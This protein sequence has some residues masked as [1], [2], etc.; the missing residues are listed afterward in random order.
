MMNWADSKL[1]NSFADEGRIFLNYVLRAEPEPYLVKRYADA[2]RQVNADQPLDLPVL[3]NRFPSLLRFVEPLGKGRTQYQ[4]E[5]IKR[6]QY[7]VS[8][9]E[10]DPSGAG[11]FC[12]IE[13][14]NILVSLIS[15]GVA[16]LTEILVLPF[17][18][19]NTFWGK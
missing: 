8:L 5:L 16:V 2:L 10:T 14:N 4:K 11:A 1:N 9:A 3:I 12:E 13:N 18:L 15:I 7:A 17:R 6:I 19:I